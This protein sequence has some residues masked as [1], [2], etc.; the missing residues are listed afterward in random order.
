M[1]CICSL[2]NLRATLFRKITENFTKMLF[3]LFFI[4][5]VRENF[6]EKKKTE[7]LRHCAKE[8]LR[9]IG[10]TFAGKIIEN[11]TKMFFFQLFLLVCVR[12]CN[13]K[14]NRNFTARRAFR[15]RG[16]TVKTSIK[17]NLS[18]IALT[19]CPRTMT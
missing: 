2:T 3:S 18:S 6:I 13:E 17:C 10:G 5:F 16:G 7:N 4:L 12:K 1:F 15:K 11:F 9:K 8:Q 14:K 19:K